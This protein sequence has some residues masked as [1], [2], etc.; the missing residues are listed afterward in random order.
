M[1]SEKGSEEEEGRSRMAEKIAGLG[2]VAFWI[3]DLV[4]G[5]LYVLKG[6]RYI[7]ISVGGPGDQAIKMKK[8]K[9]LAEIVLKRL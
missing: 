2:D 5:A 8:S 4:G 9:M 7:R 3:V 6:N 1:A